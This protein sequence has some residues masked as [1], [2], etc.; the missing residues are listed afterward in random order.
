MRDH[1]D[2][3]ATVR[4]LEP[5]R[6]NAVDSVQA[7]LDSI[8]RGTIPEPTA[9]ERELA[10][11]EESIRNE[12]KLNALRNDLVLAQKNALE[13]SEHLF[14]LNVPALQSALTFLPFIISAVVELG[15]I[16]GAW[17]DR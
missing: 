2:G 13:R 6:A 15:I 3:P 17:A 9:A 16:A 8:A 5:G 10:R 1:L 7:V 14:A 11:A 12:A 4:T